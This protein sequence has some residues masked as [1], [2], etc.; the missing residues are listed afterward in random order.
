MIARNRKVTRTAGIVA[1]LAA[2]SAGGLAGCAPQQ[3]DDGEPGGTLTYWS[4]WK[5]GEPQQVVLAAAIEEFESSTDIEVDVQWSGREVI[6][7]IT[8]R[9]A[10]GNPPDLFDQAGSA[11]Q[12]SFAATDG[13]LGLDDVY[14]SNPVGEEK[15][16][17]EVIPE[18]VAELYTNDDGEPI[19]V[20]YEVTGV[21]LWYNGLKV[22]DLTAATWADFTAE[23]GELKAAGGSPIAVDGDQPYYENYWF[24][25]AAIRHGGAEAVVAI[26]TDETGESAKDPAIVAA[27]DEVIALI[28][29]GYLPEDFAGT[30][31]PAQ[32]TAWADGSN[33]STF[34]AM[35][36]WAPSETGSALE[37]SGI[38]VESVIDYR[39]IPFPA[40][41]GGAGNDVVWVDD[42]GFAIPSK[43]RNAEAAK[44][45]IR[46]FT[47]KDQMA[48]IASDADNLTPRADIEPPAVLADFAAEYAAGVEAD[49]LV[50]APDATIS[51]PNWA[52]QVLFPIVGELFNGKFDD[53]DAFAEALK[54]RTVETLAAQD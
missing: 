29:A 35:G 17:R 5:E 28:E 12:S 40:A 32:Q 24:T 4:M 26:S 23:L 53:G 37:K 46:F 48:G 16:I 54:Q 14:D 31:W 19:L 15:K 45:F 33:D 41:E 47:A 7:Q 34:L 42:F 18:A 49:S 20:P 30:K 52:N 8:P 25:Y 27:A 38:D 3:G 9:L 22:P 10:A 36:T 43:A 50:T 11:I 51:N 2:V 44:E 6:Q 13:V 39:S 21:T 1:A